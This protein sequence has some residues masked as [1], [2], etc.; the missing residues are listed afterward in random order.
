MRDNP[1]CAQQEYDRILDSAD[2]GLSVSL[3]FDPAE[4]VAAPF[5]RMAAP[6]VPEARLR[7][8]VAALRARFAAEVERL[9][10]TAR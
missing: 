8:A 10:P 9:Y 2:K 6:V 4:D 3:T 5:V 7:T 1:E